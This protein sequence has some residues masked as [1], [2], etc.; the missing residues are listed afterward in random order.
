MNSQ[1]ILNDT[2]L[3]IIIGGVGIDGQGT[4][5]RNTGTIWDAAQVCA[6]LVIVDWMSD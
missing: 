6:A 2:Y 3:C 1:A 4:R 5:R